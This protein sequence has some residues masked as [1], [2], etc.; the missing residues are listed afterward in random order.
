MSFVTG[1]G[2]FVSWGNYYDQTCFPLFDAV[3]SELLT[4]APAHVHK[5]IRAG[6]KVIICATFVVCVR[7]IESLDIDLW[8]SLVCSSGRKP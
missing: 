8:L 5:H 4:N 7:S 2:Y 6:G 1:L 3:I